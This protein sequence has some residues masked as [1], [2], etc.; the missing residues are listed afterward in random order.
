MGPS[1]GCCR[2]KLLVGVWFRVPESFQKSLIKEY[3]L[4][5]IGI[6]SMI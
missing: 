3:A 6:L 4:N 5:D 2:H 1:E